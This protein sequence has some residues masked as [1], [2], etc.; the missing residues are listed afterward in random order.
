MA[1]RKNPFEN[2][3]CIHIIEEIETD[4]GAQ[5]VLKLNTVGSSRQFKQILCSTTAFTV[6]KFGSVYILD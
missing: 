3:K 1:Q 4:H 6:I 5:F 2:K